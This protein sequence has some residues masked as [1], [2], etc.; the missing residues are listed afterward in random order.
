MIT[1]DLFI[2]S[3]YSF[4]GSLLDLDK[5]I[6]RAKEYGFKTLGLT[7]QNCLYGAL[8][9]Y[10]KCHE[11]GI[12]PIIGL[13]VTIET[14]HYGMTPFLLYAK[15]DIGYHNLI[16]ISSII[17][18]ESKILTITK[19][20]PW[21]E[22]IIG[23]AL[24]SNGSVYQALATDDY[25]LATEQCQTFSRNFEAFYLGIDMTD[26]LT[27][28]KIGSSALIIWDSIIVNQVNYL[29]Y[30][31]AHA[32]EI[33]G[34][35][36][37][38]QSS[39]QSGMFNSNQINHSLRKPVQLDELN[40]ELKKAI[41]NTVRMIASIQL[42]IEFGKYRLPKYPSLEGM[43]ASDHLSK[44]A[45]K[46][47]KR[48]FM[49]MK[50]QLFSYETYQKRLDY[51]LQIIHD[52][53]FD[54]YFLIVWD[55]VLYAKKNKILVGPG[56]GSSAGSLVS[57]VLGIVDVDPLEHRLFFERFLN[58]ERIT[59]PDI[60]MDF[61]DDKRDE[62]IRYV[63]DKY[64]KDR[65]TN[66]IAFGTFQGKSAIRDAARI[67]KTNENVI[68]ELT[69][70]VSDTDNSLSGFIRLNPDKYQYYMSDPAIK[71]LLDVS[72]RI[73]GLQKHVSTHAAGIIITDQPITSYSPVQ[74][75]LL[76]M[77]QTQYEASDL[78]SIGL[79]KIDFLGIRNL[80]IISKVIDQIEYDTH[81][82][83]DI[84]KIPTDDQKTFE[85]LKDV[86]TLGIFQLESQGM[87]NLLRKM[88]ISNFDD[89]AVCIALF[90]PGPMENI[91]TYLERRFQIEPITYTHKDLEPILKDTNGII[92]YQEQ[93]MQI[94]NQFAGYSMGEADVLRRAVSKK[95][96][97]V[98][99]QERD[100]FVSKC[101]E[102][103]HDQA[104]SNDIYDYIVKFANYGFNK[105]HSV[106]YA[107]VAYWMAYLKA[108]YPSYFMASLLDNAIGSSSATN[109]YIRECRK[110]NIK[111]LPPRIN[112]SKKYYQREIDGLRYPYLGIRGIGPVIADKIETLCLEKPVTTFLDFIRRSSGI[113]SKAIESMILVGVFDGLNKTKQTL[114]NNLRQAESFIAFNQENQDDMF[115]YLES[116]EYD[117]EYLNQIERNLLGI[118]LS[119]HAL[120]D[121]ANTIEKNGYITP[122]EVEDLRLGRYQIA[123]VLSRIKTIRTK[124]GSE[125]CFV[126]IE[127]QLSSFEGVIFSET[128]VRNKDLILKGNVYLFEGNLDFRNNKKQLV[129]ENIKEIVR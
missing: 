19:M 87:M 50:N 82:K 67:L 49:M 13:S 98:L 108:N 66:I 105:S 28:M 55:F 115:I 22:G 74:N 72:T 103:G 129:I 5:L 56:R 104:I 44:L 73:E 68:D 93:I 39:S 1:F 100:K 92:V 110:L 27:E 46:G 8:K 109:D 31:D 62:V 107:L 6:L 99:I 9:F 20:Q 24:T 95:K 30:E 34:L 18:T 69:S 41:D 2:Q 48:R 11:V 63:V 14:E 75:G 77:Y 45:N 65:V 121:Y 12:K 117:F 59:M 79:L 89:I 113:N 60:D 102:M 3:S 96:E 120:T 16:Q 53:G 127:D 126:E 43:S 42:T 81:E 21:K 47:L 84:Y 128:W 23:V 15:N 70:L 94:A 76:G 91:P 116:P 78:E 35:I 112:L 52:M 124:K 111:V 10:K 25:A 88:Q 33:L 106:V 119:F 61:P 122:S 64:G 54:D 36:L 40:I 57:Y 29:D 51:E 38:E 123:G 125:M 80:A 26:P 32:S 86:R 71:E 7:D 85:L 90:R 118:N 114:I 4:N 17:N 58:P 97:D 101:V 37:N 83:I